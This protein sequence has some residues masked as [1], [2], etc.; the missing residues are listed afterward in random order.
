MHKP[1]INRKVSHLQSTS[2]LS[3]FSAAVYNRNERNKQIWREV[4][5]KRGKARG[6]A[7]FFSFLR[8][9]REIRVQQGHSNVGVFYNE[10]VGAEKRRFFGERDDGRDREVR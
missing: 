9:V 6:A 3:M 5:S 10:V 8:N 1:S 4:V 7:L 2:I